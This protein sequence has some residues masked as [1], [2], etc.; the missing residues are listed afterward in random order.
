M[1]LLDTS[2]CDRNGAQ[3]LLIYLQG[4]IGSASM[5]PIHL[6]ST[7]ILHPW[8]DVYNVNHLLCS[9]SEHA[10]WYGTSFLADT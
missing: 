1:S 9:V 10:T 8:Y 3:I 2:I 4:Y 5:L 7:K 6:G